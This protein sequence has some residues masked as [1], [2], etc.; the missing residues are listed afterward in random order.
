MR[1]TSFNALNT[2]R[3]HVHDSRLLIYDARLLFLFNITLITKA[4]D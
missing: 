3:C 4:Y 1:Y 2:E